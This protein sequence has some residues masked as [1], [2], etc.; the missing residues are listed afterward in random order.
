M[1]KNDS[2][3]AIFELENVE[4]NFTMAK[5]LLIKYGAF[6]SFHEEQ[7]RGYWIACSDIVVGGIVSVDMDTKTVTFNLQTE[8]HYF[9]VGKRVVKRKKYSPL[10][11]LKTFNNY[12]KEL[13]NA[14]KNLNKWSKRL[15]WGKDTKVE[16]IWDGK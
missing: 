4:Q 7:L 10:G 11:Y 9:R 13:E 8:R 14:I 5:L 6:H 15:L 16:V 1:E 12:G 3:D 2:I